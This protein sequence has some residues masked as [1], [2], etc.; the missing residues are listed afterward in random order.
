MKP[1]RLPRLVIT[2]GSK[3]IGKA[4]C[5]YLKDL[6]E[7]EDLSR[8]TGHDLTKDLP[9]IHAEALVLCAGAWKGTLTL[10]YH[11]PKMMLDKIDKKTHVVLI[12]SNAAYENY[13]ND[14]YTTAKAGLLL[15]A[16]RMVKEGYRI[17]CI[18]P[19]TVNTDFW[20]D[21]E[22]DNRTKCIPI[23]PIEVARCVALALASDSLITELIILPRKL[24]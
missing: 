17:T 7:I 5:E 16:R 3:G 11:S 22:V 6:Y 10:N 23:E 19:G 13:G 9:P 1:N 18:S 14:D 12:L 2:G 20:K 4:I 8:T 15:K 24:K 21:A